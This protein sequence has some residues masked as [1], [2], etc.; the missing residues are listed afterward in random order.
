VN[1][2][3]LLSVILTVTAITPLA[4]CGGDDSGDASTTTRTS[5]AGSPTPDPRST[6][7]LA[8]TIA[9][10]PQYFV[11]IASPGDTLAFVA[12]AFDGD[13]GAPPT[14][15]ID[16]LKAINQLTS[17]TLAGGQQ[18][19]VPLRLPGDLSLIPD[20]SIEAAIGA[21]SA[22]GKLALLQPSLAMRDGFQNR[23]VLRFVQLADGS[24]AAEGYGYVMDYWLA[25]RPPFKGGGVDP[26]ARAVEPLFSVAGGSLSAMVGSG[27]H[28]GPVHRF[29]RDGVPY[30]VWAAPAAGKTPAEIA[31]LLQTAAQR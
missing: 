31:V 9:G 12:D 25:D 11:Y 2:A 13:R 14:A 5:A 17:E 30:A 1:A 3:R 6:P 20:G 8:Q 10:N 22:G 7:S 26:E 27:P 15:F 18:L 19:A 29:T 23:V 4:A 16:A 28:L 24:P 21:G